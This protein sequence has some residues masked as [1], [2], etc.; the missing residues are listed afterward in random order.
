MLNDKSFEIVDSNSVYASA[1]VPK[2]RDANNGLAKTEVVRDAL[3]EG[4]E[5]MGGK[6][7]AIRMVTGMVPG[8]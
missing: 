4:A 7:T 2:I 8:A 6:L 1:A 5:A 3:L